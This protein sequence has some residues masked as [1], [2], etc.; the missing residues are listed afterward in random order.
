[1]SQVGPIGMPWQA[2]HVLE[3]AAD[4]DLAGEVAGVRT[5]VGDVVRIDR[6][7]QTQDHDQDEDAAEEQRDLVA[8]QPS[9]REPVGA[10]SGRT[11]CSARLVD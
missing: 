4:P 1:M 7:Q 6:R 11:T 10:D 9:P 3:L 8:A 2:E 5:D